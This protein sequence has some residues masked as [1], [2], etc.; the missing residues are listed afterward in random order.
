MTIRRLFPKVA[1]DWSIILFMVGLLTFNFYAMRYVDPGATVDG[2][3]GIYVALQVLIIGFAAASLAATI[4]WLL[5]Y[6]L[7]RSEEAKLF[8]VNAATQT[9][10]PGWPGLAA[11]ALDRLTWLAVWLALF[12]HS[13]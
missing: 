12:S 1:R 2:L 8:G 11:I 13:V 3:A 6:P 9:L 5:F 7:R 4:R 10:A